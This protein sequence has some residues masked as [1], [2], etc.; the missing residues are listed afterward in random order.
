[1][2]KHDLNIYICIY[3]VY[4]YDKECGKHKDNKGDKKRDRERE[5]HTHTHRQRLWVRA[6]GPEQEIAGRRA[7]EDD[8][9][10]TSWTAVT[11]ALTRHH[12]SIC[13]VLRD[14]ACWTTSSAREKLID[15]RRQH[16]RRTPSSAGFVARCGNCRT[17]PLFVTL[18]PVE[19]SYK[20]RRGQLAARV[21][22]AT[23]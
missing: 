20:A 5:T 18:V 9:F 6:E 22:K 21:A 3:R 7:Q 14:S 4:I 15:D 12:H 10:I 19:A 8:F 2:G 23:S 1:M 17:S 13:K 16:D 11:D